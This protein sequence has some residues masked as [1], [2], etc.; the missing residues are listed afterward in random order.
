MMK[1]RDA[2]LTVYLTLCLTLILS[3]YLVLIDG[4]RRNGA[5][6]EAV[7]ATE[8]GL[9]SIMAEYHRELL[10]QYNLFAIDSSYGTPVSGRKNTEAHLMEYIKTNLSIHDVFLADY[11]YRDFFGLH[12]DDAE[13]TGVSILTDGEGAVFRDRAIEAVKDDVGLHL[14]EELEEWMQIIEVNGLEASVPEEEKREI[15]EKIEEFNGTEIQISDDESTYVQIENPTLQLEEKRHLGILSLV[16]D[17]ELSENVINTE[18]LIQNRMKQGTINHG[19]MALPDC[20][21]LLSRFL[22]QEYLLRYMDFFGDIQEEDALHYQIEYLIVGK[23]SDID[24]L[25]SIANRISI[26]R[27]A[28]NAAYLLADKEKRLE[29]QGAA[30][31]VCGAFALPELIPLVEAAILLGWAYAESIYDVKS[32]F[33]GGKI[34]LMK[35]K[36]NWHYSLES[37]LTGEL[38]DNG[39]ENSGLAYKDYLRIFM[40]LTNLDL[41]TARAMDMVEA[42]IRLTDENRNFRLDACYDGLE[43]SVGISSSFG[44]KFVIERERTY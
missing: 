25:R 8:A 21:D 5:G 22:F 33:S 20:N 16:T 42:D 41:L 6:L 13:L 34:P 28:A 15:D 2:Y 43:V 30:T 31:L 38:Q 19:N 10:E 18:G 40:M 27:E 1:G 7:C 11:L 23:D 44:Y 35:D 37:A 39:Q 17:E 12:A 14:L 3:L 29:I 36:D 26:L 9:Q 24:N 32:L 4:A